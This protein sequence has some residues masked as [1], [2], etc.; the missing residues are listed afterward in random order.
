MKLEIKQAAF[1]YGAK[2]VFDNVSLSL[3]AGEVL[4]ILGPNG[5]GKTTLFKV[6]LGFLKPLRGKVLLNGESLHAR[7][8]QQI[9]RLI[10]YVPQNHTPPF[11]FTVRDVVLMGRTAHL[12]RFAA[13]SKKDVAIAEQALEVLKIAHLRDHMYT[14]ISGGE[15]QLVL[16]ARALAQQPQILIMDEPTSN[17]D[18]GNQVKVLHHIKRLVAG[19]LAVIMSTHHPDHALLFATKVALMKGGGLIEVGAPEDVITAENLHKIYGVQAK[20]ASFSLGE[21]REVKTCLPLL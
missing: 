9:A 10:G 11:P 6:V 18:F 12:A 7:T 5:T 16:I 19:G 8:P 14:E 3:E 13:P 4:S 15:R 2:K 20:V 21:N 1:Q 17:L